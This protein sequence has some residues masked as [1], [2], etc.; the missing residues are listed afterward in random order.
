MTDRKTKT[1]I[2]LVVFI[3]TTILLEIISGLMF[4]LFTGADNSQYRHI[5]SYSIIDTIAS[6]PLFLLCTKKI[7]SSRVL[8]SLFFAITFILKITLIVFG[9][10]VQMWYSDDPTLVVMT[11]EVFFILK[12]MTSTIV[13]IA[14]F[15]FLSKTTTANNKQ[16]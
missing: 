9:Y 15:F 14:L 3:L 13:L 16:K 5:Y 10:Y 2:T 12:L 6:L 4:V 8:T 1:F 7:Q 11:G